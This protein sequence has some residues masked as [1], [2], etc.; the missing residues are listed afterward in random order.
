MA[1]TRAHVQGGERASDGGRTIR[2]SKKKSAIIQCLNKHLL[3]D[4]IRFRRSAAALCSN[5]AKSCYDRITLLAAVLCLCRLGCS[6]PSVASM[7]T[8][9]HDMQ[10]HIRTT[11]GDSA[12]AATRQ[13]WQAPIAGIGQGNGAGPQ[14]WAAVSSPMIEIMRSDGFYAQVVSAISL[15]SRQIV[16]FAFVDDTDLCVFG[17]HVHSQNVATEMQ[18]SVNHWEGLLRA[19]GGALVPTK[20]FWY[21]IDF[22]WANNKWQYLTTG[23][24]SGSLS[25]RDD[26]QNRV[27]IPRLEPSEAR[28]TLGVRLAPDGNWTAEVA[29]LHSIAQDWQV[30]MAASKLSSHDAMFSLKNVVLRKLHYPLTTTTFTPQQCLQIMTP[31]LKQGLPKAGVVRTFPRALAHGPLQ[32]GGLDIPYMYTKQLIAHV[33]TLLRYGPHPDDLTGSLLHA[34][35]ESM[36]LETGYI[37]ELLSVPLILA[38]NVTNSWLKHVWQ[39]TQAVAISISTDFAE[40][41]I[42][43]HGDQAIMRLFMRSGRKQPELHILNQ[44]RMFL[45]VF[46]LSDIVDGSGN[47]ILAQFWDRPR[48]MDSPHIWPPTPSPTSSSWDLWRHALSQ[49]LNLGRH[50]RLALPLGKWHAQTTPTGWFYHRPTHSL[51]RATSTH[52]L[53]HGSQ[54]QRTRQQQFHTQGEQGAPPLLS[55]LEKAT[56]SM[57]GTQ[58]ILTGNQPCTPAER[59]QDSC[60]AEC[61]TV[62]SKQ[63]GLQLHLRGSQR[64]LL[65]SLSRGEGFAVSDGSYKDDKGTAAWIIEGPSSVLRLTG[66]WFTPGQ[67]ED[68]SSFRSEL[69]GLLGVVYTLTFWPPTTTAPTFRLACDGLSVINRLTNSKPIEP[70]EPHAD[71]LAAVRSMIASCGYHIVLQFVRGHQ[72]NGHPTVLA[73]DA[74]LNVEADLLAKQRVAT[75]HTG[76]Q[77][78]SLPGNPWSCYIGTRRVVKQL[79][80]TLRTF[81]NGKDAL[82]YWEQR[83]NYT[84]AQLQEVDWMSFARAMKSVPLTQHRWVSKHTSGH[85]AHGKNMVRWKQCTSDVCPRCATP[86]E[87]KAHI[88]RCPQEEAAAVW[89]TAVTAFTQWMKDEQTDPSIIQAIAEGLAMWRSGTTTNNDTPAFQKQSWLGWDAALDGWLTTEWRAQQEQYWSQWQRKKS[90]KRWATELIKKLWNISWE[91]CAHRNGVLHDAQQQHTDIIDSQLNSQLTAL[92]QCGVHA[93]PRD[94]FRF[95]NKP[96]EE[97]LQHTSNYK[98][99][100]IRSVEAAIER[101]RNHNFGQYLE[102][103][104]FMRTWLGLEA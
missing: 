57:L 49:S 66:S 41:P 83:R 40:I 56:V 3:Y 74:W 22:K 93:V 29:Y 9:I 11:F 30:K 82:H 81:I 85:F 8:T 99:K 92:Y 48:P 43:R 10:H 62:F 77:L 2:Q 42:Q 101:K 35:A 53:R 95:F 28:R 86:L 7:I 4:L 75:N 5:D 61:Q 19:T 90:S 38:D 68:H 78:Y 44:C 67:P 12:Q 23:Q 103:Q 18:R 34:T 21:L 1:G 73:R 24:A 65:Q 50:Q 55:E 51:W 104:R 32:Y 47:S 100:W 70:T 46:L 94:A 64:A 25:I 26:S 14:I 59:I 89:S 37:G 69:A 72:D 15:I 16:G 45:H 80:S 76:P 102:E 39:S 60:Q 87:D 91:M 6:T 54:P 97:L 88:T 98:D 96:L 27:S 17:Q 84:Q 13:S 52:W 20:C 63:W 33:T 31:I 79:V 71:L 58:L 36:R